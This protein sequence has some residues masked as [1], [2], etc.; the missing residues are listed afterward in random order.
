MDNGWWVTGGSSEESS[1]EIWDGENWKSSIN[2]PK[3]LIGHCMVKIN[4]SHVFITGGQDNDGP[5]RASYIYNG[6]EFIQVAN[7]NGHRFGPAC[8]LHD[9]HIFVFGGYV[10]F[11]TSEVFSLKTSTWSEGPKDVFGNGL[12]EV[13]IN[14][15]TYI[16]GDEAIYRL[17]TT[18]E[19][20]WEVVKIID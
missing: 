17:S 4:S 13:S 14:G 9:D 7:I 10:D 18:G 19:D 2:L 12:S 8:C 6:V 5:N 3:R 15:I 16:I 1:T 20:S 11:S